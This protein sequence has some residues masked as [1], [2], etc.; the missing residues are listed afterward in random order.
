MGN[1]LN[2][3]VYLYEA[4]ATRPERTN[5]EHIRRGQYEGLRK[6]IES[7]PERQPDYGPA[8]LGTAGA[9]VIGAREPLIAFNVYLTTD[10]VEIA[11]KIAKAIRHSSGGLRYV[12]AL[13]LLVEGHAQVS[14][15]LT[16]FHETPIARVVE[17][18]RRE[19]QRYGV[20]I[21]HS[22]LVGL[23]PQEALV[24]AAVWYTQLDAF[25]TGQILEYR[26]I[27]SSASAPQPKPV[28]F[29]EELAA[30]TATP[31]GGS[32]GA[33]AGAMGA[34]LV[35]MV[36]GLTIG[37]KKYAQVEA[38]MQ[39]VRVMAENLRKE[40]TH[41]VEDDSA[42]FEAVMGAFQ[43]PKGTEEEQTKR[44]VA[45]HH[46]TL[47]AAHVPLKVA[48]DSVKVMELA[49]K[50]AKE[51]NVNAI[52]DSMSGF[53]MVRASLTASTYNVKINLNSLADKSVGEK[54]LEELKELETKANGL[55]QEIRK[56]METRGG[57]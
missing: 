44:D 21:H 43:L 39:A 50:C 52:S 37:K 5:L 11:K 28:S 1:E 12:K 2:I 47:N 18:V 48:K 46:A 35:A 53:A 29:I 23:I 51:G 19:T 22:E 42:A 40:L 13:G 33:Y 26:L 38:Q 17:T 25:D 36:A 7:N 24:D 4:A 55:E 56:T 20:A 32:A 6:E 31:G 45:I 8:K 34:G 27:D 30:P 9:T 10:D 16:N 14:M 41:A 3:P 49:L 15:N 57:I 54:M